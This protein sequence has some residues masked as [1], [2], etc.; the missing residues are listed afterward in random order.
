MIWLLTSLGYILMMGI[1]ARRY[2]VAYI[3][4]HGRNAI[5]DYNE[6][7]RP[8]GKPHDPFA[9]PFFA[10]MCW[11]FTITIYLT[12]VFVRAFGWLW[13]RTI[14]QPTAAE[15]K[16]ASAKAHQEEQRLLDETSKQLGLPTINFTDL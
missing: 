11:P 7:G 9:L 12:I 3:T 14:T 4:K 6:R 15:R 13:K 10:G 5:Q 8:V 2:F 1:V 16:A